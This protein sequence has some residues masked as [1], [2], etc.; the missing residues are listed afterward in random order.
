MLE[1]TTGIA[2]ILKNLEIFTNYYYYIKIIVTILINIDFILFNIPVIVIIVIAI[3]MAIVIVM[4]IIFNCLVIL[5]YIPPTNRFIAQT[6][7]ARAIN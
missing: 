1:M 5:F 6:R 4:A 2:I 7:S 3:A